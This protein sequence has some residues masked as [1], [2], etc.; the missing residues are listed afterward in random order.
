MSTVPGIPSTPERPGRAGA[1]LRRVLDATAVAAVLIGSLATAGVSGVSASPPRV[2]PAHVSTG[3]AARSLRPSRAD[4][5]KIRAAAR[6]RMIA[7]AAHRTARF[8]AF[9]AYLGLTELVSIRSFAP[10][11]CATAVTD[12][13]DNLLDLENAY[14]GENW[15][16]L[17]R[18]VAKQP[19][20]HACAPRR[21]H[22]GRPPSS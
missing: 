3:S 1:V 13:Y 17:R 12:L 16:P 11:R 9:A 15:N 6:L 21:Q 22:D 20:I 4:W 14:P 8:R 5:E 10:G 18:A 7:L 2:L 19:S